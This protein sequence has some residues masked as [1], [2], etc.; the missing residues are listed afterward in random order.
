MM[1]THATQAFKQLHA[2]K[3]KKSKKVITLNNHGDDG[4]IDNRNR[5]SAMVPWTTSTV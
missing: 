2:K 5:P 1:S 3:K 4:L